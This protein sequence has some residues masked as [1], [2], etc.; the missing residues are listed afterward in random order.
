MERDP[1]NIVVTPHDGKV[2][3]LLGV[4]LEFIMQASDTDGA[5][6]LVEYTAPARF[7]GPPP[8]VHQQAEEAFYVLEGSPTFQLNE[9]IIQAG[10]GMT[11]FIPRGA[12]HTFS[13]AGDTP[14]RFLIMLSPA[15]FEEYW[16]ELPADDLLTLEHAV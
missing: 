1:H 10:P 6:S 3:S 14:A 8:H 2:L 5:W 15:G 16:V 13:N 7:A 9:E 12:V 4:T 11:V